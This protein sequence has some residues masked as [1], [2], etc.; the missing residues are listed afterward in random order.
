ME[1]VPCPISGDRDFSPWIEAPDRFDLGGS[2]WPI[3]RS[4]TSGLLMLNPRPEE[5][6]A[7]GHYP[8]RDYDPFLHNGNAGSARD[9]AYL[10]ASSVLMGRKASIVMDGLR[11]PAGSVR[12]LETGCSTGRLLNRLRRKYGIP[13]QNLW[14]IEPDHLAASAA[15]RSGLT[16]IHETAI[17]E[18]P[19]GC[20][21]DR[22]VLWHVLEHIHRIGAALDSAFRMLE[23]DGRL[24][25][26]LPNV[27]S[28]DAATY[29]AGWIAL[30]APRHLYHFT[31]ETLGRLLARHG[32]SVVDI[33][34]FAPDTLYN[35]W[36]S[37]KLSATMA[38]RRFGI[39]SAAR[40]AACAGRSIL[41]G[42]DP[43]KASVFV[44]RAERRRQEP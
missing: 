44:C 26:A 41:N 23:P 5:S 11:K 42:S 20:C 33:R 40:A 16:H 15:R 35:V 27:D 30:D 32:F 7:S 10:L 36:Y 1:L 9:R 43:A 25:I 38:G 13:A 3:V 17:D 28:Y 31:P 21:F 29:V 8:P 34:A 39:R 19:F 18:T 12:I 37:E 6:E 22:I 24:V 2:T 4:N 14:G